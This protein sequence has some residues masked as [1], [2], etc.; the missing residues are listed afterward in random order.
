MQMICIDSKKINLSIVDWPDLKIG[1][2]DRCP[3]N[4]RQGYMP[5]LLLYTLFV[6]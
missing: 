5:F 6:H 3:S 1:Q 4:D 2:Q